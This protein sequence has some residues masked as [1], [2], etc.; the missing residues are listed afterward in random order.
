MIDYY[1]DN[2][3]LHN[4]KKAKTVIA[5]LLFGSILGNF[6]TFIS[7]KIAFFSIDIQRITLCIAVIIVAVEVIKSKNFKVNYIMKSNFPYMLLITFWTLIILFSCF[8]LLISSYKIE[9][10]KEIFQLLIVASLIFLL[11]FN[12]YNEKLLFFALRMTKYFISPLIIFSY[13][14]MIIGIRLDG[15][16][17]KSPSLNNFDTTLQIPKAYF[18]NPNDFASVL[19]LLY[20]ILIFELSYAKNKKSIILNMIYMILS[21]I[22]AIM[23]DSSIWRIT[24]YVIILIYIVTL[25]GGTKNYRAVKMTLIPS[26]ISVLMLTICKPFIRKF[27]LYLNIEMMPI[28]YK[29]NGPIKGIISDNLIAG[30]SLMDQLQ[31]TGMGTFNVRKNLFLNGLELSKDHP[32]IGAG[33]GGFEREISANMDKLLP[34]DNIV[35]PHNLISELMVEYGYIVL[36][37]FIIFM[38]FTFFS[39]LKNAVKSDSKISQIGVLLIG[40]FIM[41]T[42]MP[43]SFMT[44]YNYWISLIFG[45]VC[46]RFVKRKGTFNESLSRG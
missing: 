25:I 2:E 29:T 33:P 41:S 6:F 22:P 9:I 39:L 23:I 24:I 3:N 15:A 21:I 1:I 35:N 37:I 20:I 43:S 13:A 12:I 17:Y 38:L 36:L 14:E 45:L 44:A 16:D 46:Y 30:D 27:I 31:E 42:V 5:I 11:L 32:F 10:A 26:I 28:F 40:G 8:N 7:L 34:T 19:I 18:E 4:E